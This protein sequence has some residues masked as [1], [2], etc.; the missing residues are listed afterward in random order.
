MIEAEGDVA[1]SHAAVLASLDGDRS[2]LMM[3]L[4]VL[5]GLRCRVFGF[6]PSGFWRSN[7]SMLFFTGFVSSSLFS[8]IDI[9]VFVD[10]IEVVSVAKSRLFTELAALLLA[11]TLSFR[12]LLT[13]C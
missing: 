11:L 7:V 1:L 13:T 2:F 9:R 6:I 10:G 3:G 4:I 8:N 12:C 5:G